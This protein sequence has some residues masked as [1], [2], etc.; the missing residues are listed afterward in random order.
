MA[1][2]LG[3]GALAVL[4][5]TV[6]GLFF[7]TLPF[8]IAAWILGARLKEHVPQHPHAGVAVLLGIIGTVLGVVAGGLYIAIG[9]S[10]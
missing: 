1:L 6:G 7:L 10:A 9:P 5:F 3:A 8:S 2:A 4:V